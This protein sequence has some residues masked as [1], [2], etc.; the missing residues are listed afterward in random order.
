MKK[1]SRNHK[2]QFQSKPSIAGLFIVIV[3]MIVGIVSLIGVMNDKTVDEPCK[4]ID[5]TSAVLCK[6]GQVYTDGI[7]DEF[8]LNKLVITK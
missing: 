5:A 8:R 6:D 3:V 4:L 2:G 7:P 1:Q